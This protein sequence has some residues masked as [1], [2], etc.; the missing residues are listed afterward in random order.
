MNNKRTVV[1]R[2]SKLCEDEIIQILDNVDAESA[3]SESDAESP[4][5]EEKNSNWFRKLKQHFK[6][7]SIQLSKDKHTDVRLQQLLS[8]ADKLCEKEIQGLKNVYLVWLYN[9]EKEFDLSD[10]P[11]DERTPRKRQILKDLY[12][13]NSPTSCF[14]LSR[15]DENKMR[16]VSLSCHFWAINKKG[17]SAYL[18]NNQLTNSDFEEII[19]F[20]GFKSKWRILEPD[21]TAITLRSL[22]RN[23]N[24]VNKSYRGHIL[25]GFEKQNKHCR[26]ETYCPFSHC[27]AEYL[28]EYDLDLVRLSRKYEKNI[29][30]A[31]ASKRALIFDDCDIGSA[32]S[33]KLPKL[34]NSSHVGSE[35]L[36]QNIVEKINTME[37]DE[38]TVI[39]SNDGAQ[40]LSKTLSDESMQLSND[41]VPCTYGS[42][43]MSMSDSEYMLSI[44][45]KESLENMYSTKNEEQPVNLSTVSSQ[46]TCKV[47]SD[48]P[49]Q[50]SLNTIVPSTSDSEY[51]SLSDIRST[52]HREDS[53]INYVNKGSLEE[54][55][56]GQLDILSN[57]GS[58]PISKISSDESFQH[59][60]TTVQSISGSEYVS[61]LNAE[62]LRSNYHQKNK[63]KKSLAS[64]TEELELYYGCHRCEKKFGSFGG[65]KAHYTS[66]HKED[67]KDIADSK[68]HICSKSVKYLDVHMRTVHPERS[69]KKCKVCGIEKRSKKSHRCISC[70][71]CNDYENLNLK[72]LLNHI[73]NCGTQM[74]PLDLSNNR[75][76]ND[77]S[78]SK[79]KLDVL[80]STPST[81]NSEGPAYSLASESLINANE[82]ADR[83][84]GVDKE[85]PVVIPDNYLH[86]KRKCYP[87]KNIGEDDGYRSEHCE[88]DS[89]EDTLRR[90][91]T[92][93]ELERE[94][95]LI[96]DIE[97][98]DEK[99]D[100]WFIDKFE[101]YM[102]KVSGGSDVGTVKEYVGVVRN[103]LLTTFHE[104]H[105]PFSAKWLLDCEMDKIM[106]IQN[107]E[108]DKDMLK[109]P[110]YL[111]SLV[112][113]SVLDKVKSG[114]VKKM[115]LAA[116]K[117]L[118]GFIELE[119]S[120]SI[121]HNGL[122]PLHKISE[123]H[124]ALDVY[125]QGNAMWKGAWDEVRKTYNNNK[126]LRDF[127]S[128]DKDL[129]IWEASQK[130]FNGAD[131]QAK[132]EML[133]K[134]ATVNDLVPSETEM[135]K[136]G[137]ALQEEI[138]MSN[139][140][141]PV[142][143]RR[144]TMG[145][146]YESTP[147]FNP[148]ETTE[149]DSV[150]RESLN[151]VNID[152]RYVYV[153]TSMD[154]IFFHKTLLLKIY[155]KKTVPSQVVFR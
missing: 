139:G 146:W 147:G 98:C 136:L 14:E 82:D 143:L 61:L 29:N 10:L 67:T 60:N 113:D 71:K 112:L 129:H 45:H 63:N 39:L 34:P 35:D 152:Q 5:K 76:K 9:N 56:E 144:L 77:G 38:Q 116:I 30:S 57:V 75:S 91:K 138:I 149:G 27:N 11:N 96:E 58:Q 153:S 122:G 7:G 25:S 1:G 26:S 70:P 18:L 85:P 20:V 150:P 133:I 72:R 59:L 94:L 88:G 83:N 100:A 37:D 99:D 47:L 89:A 132:L 55:D 109:E 121:S 16:R 33:P 51:M 123:Y 107:K 110:V 50:T 137:E 103:L 64:V 81:K 90:R 28:S 93:D 21:M 128:P 135:T 84:E 125:I 140:C 41:I 145:T 111:T 104:T 74:K 105:S 46:P 108:R 40:S 115:V 36:K 148:D 6:D 52:D 141:R 131:R 114:S 80:V 32:K 43:S 24:N 151:N 54:G 154:I 69:I 87:F 2:N 130:W 42:E 106:K 44:E 65:L 126:K 118:M 31:S 53:D 97:N 8:I 48:E 127:R 134:L 13:F 66:I 22:W 12:D 79:S 142:V 155:L 17:S 101:M 15:V 4:L 23:E 78:L 62:H 19:T 68:C 124:K 119:F 49:M 92:K 102:I 95:I 3:A 86:K 120:H 73:K 117:K